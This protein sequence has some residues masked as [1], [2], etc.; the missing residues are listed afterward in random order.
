MII[1]IIM[2]GIDG[3]TSTSPAD[4]REGPERDF[5]RV[6]LTQPRQSTSGL[7]ILFR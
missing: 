6:G 2:V 1:P 3:T 7:M 5:Y 4:D